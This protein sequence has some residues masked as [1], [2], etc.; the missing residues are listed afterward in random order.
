MVNIEYKN[1][2]IKEL[3]WKSI[4]LNVAKQDCCYIW[5]LTHS[6]ECYDFIYPE[7]IVF[8]MFSGDAKW[9]HG[10]GNGLNNT[11]FL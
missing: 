7:N 8:L 5:L 6:S 2:T 11:P 9:E 10:G 1:V 3:F 4:N